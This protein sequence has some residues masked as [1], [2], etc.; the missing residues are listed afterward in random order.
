MTGTDLGPSDWSRARV[1]ATAARVC[2]PAQVEAL[3]EGGQGADREAVRDILHQAKA[4]EGLSP[5]DVATLIQVT[6]PTVREEILRAAKQVHEQVYGRRVS[7]S[8]P[9]CPS[10]R[11]VNDCLYCPL[12]RANSALRRN[13]TS[14][15]DLQ[16]E[17]VALLDEGHRHVVLVFG[18]DRKRDTLHPRHALGRLRGA[19]G[20]CDSSSGWT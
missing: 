4:R 10:N 18:D 6:D 15:R 5:A 2:D 3:L 13:A 8:T 17:I 14:A 1:E 12:R 7:L 11:C 16:R 19:L 20:G 9:V